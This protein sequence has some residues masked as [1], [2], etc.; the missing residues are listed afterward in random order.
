[1]PTANDLSNGLKVCLKCS[2][3]KPLSE[4]YY[5]DRGRPDKYSSSCKSCTSLYHKTSKERLKVPCPVCG[6]PISKKGDTCRECYHNSEKGQRHHKTISDMMLKRAEPHQCEL[7]GA[8]TDTP[9]K[10]CVLCR[11]HGANNPNWRGGMW[12]I[13]RNIRSSLAYRMW[14]SDVFTRDGFACVECGEET[15]E[16]HAHHI[17]SFQSILQK[18]EIKS[19]KEANQCDE[20]WNINNGVTLC[21]ECHR[22]KH[23]VKEN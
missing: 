22:K 6:K 17:V 7:C 20:L 10:Q 16:L 2:E 5:H 19:T 18:H 4:F 8:I 21:G 9:F 1:M 12:P 14:K 3:T 13:A 11:M 15:R 23:F